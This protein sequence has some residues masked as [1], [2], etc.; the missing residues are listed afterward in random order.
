MC[1][2]SVL[3]SAESG[4]SIENCCSRA[5][6]RPGRFRPLQGRSGPGFPSIASDDLFLIEHSHLPHAPPP[7]RRGFFFVSHYR[8]FSRIAGRRVVAGAGAKIGARV[9]GTIDR[10]FSGETSLVLSHR[11]HTAGLLTQEISR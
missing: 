3:S 1:L 5:G 2:F 10:I 11:P 7:P 8:D 6:G 9:G 4:L